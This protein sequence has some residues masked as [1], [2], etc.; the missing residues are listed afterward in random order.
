M[1]EL[2]EHELRMPDTRVIE[3]KQG[4]LT[5]KPL[6][7][8]LN[9]SRANTVAGESL[10]TRTGTEIGARLYTFREGDCSIIENKHSNRDWRLTY[11]QGE[12]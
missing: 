5:H 7:H 10:R 3:N 1:F 4:L 12:C 9:L 6:R 8:T 2:L 11:L